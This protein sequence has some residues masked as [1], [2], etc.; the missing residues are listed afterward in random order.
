[1]TF[2]EVNLTISIKTMNS[3]RNFSSGHTF[4]LLLDIVFV[5]EMIHKQGYSLKYYPY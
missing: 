2:A 4:F 3:V 1:M 5:G